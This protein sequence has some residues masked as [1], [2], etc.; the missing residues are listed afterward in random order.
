M[1]NTMPQSINPKDYL[2]DRLKQ[3]KGAK[4]KRIFRERFTSHRRW[5]ADNIG[6][7]AFCAE[8]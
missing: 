3:I 2:R 7:K 4:A 5:L 8:S 6:P 1:N